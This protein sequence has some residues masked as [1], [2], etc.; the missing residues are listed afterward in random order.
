MY[1]YHYRSWAFG[2]SIRSGHLLWL[3]CK[4]QFC[5]KLCFQFTSDQVEQRDSFQDTIL[6]QHL[7]WDLELELMQRNPTVQ[8][9]NQSDQKK[10]Q[11]LHRRVQMIFPQR[12]IFERH[13]FILARF[14]YLL[15]CYFLGEK[16]CASHWSQG[17][18]DFFKNIVSY[19][20]AFP[21]AMVWFW[22]WSISLW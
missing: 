6:W 10:Y 11:V 4:M 20:S 12:I 8:L 9:T 19:R 2:H 17:R 22:C 18:L 1:F 13:L 16:R 3:C 5:N 15:L 14:C 21:I 7:S